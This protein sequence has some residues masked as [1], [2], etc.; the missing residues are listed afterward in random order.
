MHKVDR[1]HA[2]RYWRLPVNIHLKH[3]SKQVRDIVSPLEIEHHS[4][5]KDKVLDA[6]GEVCEGD[7]NVVAPEEAG[8]GGIPFAK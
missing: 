6:V 5:E 8:G 3:G 4:L 1:Q 7:K 2:Y